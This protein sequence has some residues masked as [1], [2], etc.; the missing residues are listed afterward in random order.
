[1]GRKDRKFTLFF[2]WTLIKM[3]SFDLSDPEQQRLCFN[4]SNLQP[5]WE[6]EN[7]SKGARYA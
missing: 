1:M 3:G 2:A 4:F 5:L 7:L 6:H